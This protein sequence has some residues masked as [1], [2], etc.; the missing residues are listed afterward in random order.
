M[1]EMVWMVG[2]LRWLSDTLSIWASKPKHFIVMFSGWVFDRIFTSLPIFD[3][4][5]LV[6]G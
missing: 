1:V 2:W 5:G 4:C 6:T 3:M